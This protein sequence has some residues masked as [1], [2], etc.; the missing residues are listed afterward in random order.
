MSRWAEVWDQPG[1]GTFAK[2]IADLPVE[3]AGFSRK[4]SGIGNGSVDIPADYTRIDEITD[5][6]T[7]TGSLIRLYDNGTNVGNF[8]AD[9]ASI[10]TAE[11]GTVSVSGPGIER[12]LEHGV[13]YPW[14]W[15]TQGPTK[16][17]FPDWLY[18]LGTEEISNGGFE[19]DPTY[20]LQ[21]GGGEDGTTNPWTTFGSV[22]D[23][24]IVNDQPNARTGDFYFS[25]DPGG[26]HSG[27]Q[28]TI[29]VWPGKRNNFTVYIKESTAAARRYTAGV[30]VES[31]YT[32]HHTNAFYYS[33][34]SLAELGNVASN[35]LGTPG[36]SSDGTWQQ[37]DLDVTWGPNQTETTLIIQY[38]HHTVG[39]GPVFWVDDV[40]MGGF[41]VGVPDWVPRKFEGVTTWEASTDVANTGTYSM[42]VVRD[43]VSTQQPKFIQDVAFEEGA[44]YTA[45]VWARTPDA[46]TPTVRLRLQ[47]EEDG[48]LLVAASANLVQDTWTKLQIEFTPEDGLFFGELMLAIDETTA[49]TIYF[50]DVTMKTGLPANSPGYIIDEQLDTITARGALTWLKYSSVTAS[51]DS[52]GN[53]WTDTEM[54]IRI[55]RGRTMK[56]VLDLFAQNNYEWEVVPNPLFP[57]TEPTLPF[58][59]KVY[60]KESMGTD[61]TALSTPMLS[62]GKSFRTGSVSLRDSGPTR[63]LAEGDVGVLHEDFD[64]GL[65]TGYGRKEGYFSYTNTETDVT[66]TSLVD[67]ALQRSRNRKWGVKVTLFD[68]PFPGIDFFLGDKININIPPHLNK[69]GYRIVGYSGAWDFS[70]GHASY[71]LDV[72]TEMFDLKTPRAE[73]SGNGG[74]TSSATSA[75][76]NKILEE[77]QPIPDVDRTQFAFVNPSPVFSG[78]IEV[79][80]LVLGQNAPSNLYDYADYICDGINDQEEIHVARDEV[81]GLGGGRI[82]LAGEFTVTAASGATAPIL[83]LYGDVHYMGLR[84]GSGRGTYIE[85]QDGAASPGGT[86]AAVRL[87]NSGKTKITDIDWFLDSTGAGTG[88]ERAFELQGVQAVYV[89]QF[90]TAQNGGAGARDIVTLN[91]DETWLD[92]IGVSYSGTGTGAGIRLLGGRLNTKLTNIWLDRVHQHGIYIEGPETDMQIIG[93]TADE[94]GSTTT[95]TYDVVHIADGADRITVLGVNYSGGTLTPRYGVNVAGATSTGIIVGGVTGTGY[96]TGEINTT[97]NTLVLEHVRVEEAGTYRGSQERLN[98]TG[99]GGIAVTVTED[100]ANDRLTVDVDGTG[101]GGGGAELYDKVV[102]LGGM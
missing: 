38:D 20:P 29:P 24:Q 53:A 28:V 62:S 61:R 55:N 15:A 74:G 86:I 89:D 26:H 48:D 78:P 5:P 84:A 1:T 60:D 71:T 63:F 66:L 65:E 96:Q 58:E 50:D 70:E 41:G 17:L 52:E 82:I 36:G 102:L 7:S 97:A 32:A 51:T 23:F 72:A 33:G 18:G 40:T 25:M 39:N 73:V 59:L 12:G 83:D 21:N 94:V 14:D 9:E 49:Q 43:G 54:S 64:S 75:A 57:G 100:A 44:P 88:Y 98:F 27:M 35:G 79:Y 4:I 16:T 76:V 45:S 2:R 42:K 11:G 87:G 47:K 99:T 37:I 85:V 80:R 81:D 31:G 8:Y 19:D 6:L 95:N 92:R 91:A 69:A 30:R 10:E 90:F 46:N 101:V 22:T 67:S 56:Q 34:Y 77:F 3:R 93:L 13:V 68:P